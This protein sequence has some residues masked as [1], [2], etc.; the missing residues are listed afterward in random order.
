MIN[1]Y[2]TQICVASYSILFSFLGQPAYLLS[3]R[4][5]TMK[6]KME[7]TLELKATHHVTM[8]CTWQGQIETQNHAK[9]EIEFK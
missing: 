5:G 3:L 4:K 1:S 9:R 8:I 7:K 2:P 6:A